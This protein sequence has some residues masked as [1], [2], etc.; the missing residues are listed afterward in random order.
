MTLRK[1]KMRHS[2][3]NILLADAFHDFNVTKSVTHKIITF[4]PVDTPHISTEQVFLP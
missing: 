3:S 1:N 2:T 4:P